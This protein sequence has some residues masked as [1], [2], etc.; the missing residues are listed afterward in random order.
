MTNEPDATPKGADAV[1][2]QP[3]GAHED[4]ATPATPEGKQASE[5]E[6]EEA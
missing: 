1:R 5:E 2:P 4:S 6:G 3:G